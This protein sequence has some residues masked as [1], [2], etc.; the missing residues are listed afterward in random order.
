MQ[1]VELIFGLCVKLKTNV[2]SENH[3]FNKNERQAQ[4]TQPNTQQLLPS[5]LTII[6]FAECKVFVYKN[7][8]IQVL[9]TYQNMNGRTPQAQ[10][11]KTFQRKIYTEISQ[12]VVFGCSQHC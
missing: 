8:K 3:E 2:K 4:L 12:L 10:T 9:C 1:K 7:W 11:K 6:N 5:P